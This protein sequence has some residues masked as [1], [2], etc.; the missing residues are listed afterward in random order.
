MLFIAYNAAMPTTAAMA[1]VANNTSGAIR[2]MLQIAPPSTRPMR[3]V[4]WGVT[5][6][7]AP[8]T[9]V[10]CELIDTNVAATVTAHVAAGVQPYDRTTGTPVSAMTLGTSATGYTATAEG[11]I[12]ATR[13]GDMK[14]IPIGASNLEYEWSLGREWEVAPSRFCRVRLTSASTVVSALV[15]ILWDE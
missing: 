15:W 9:R 13:I 11:T 3:P 12:T 4:R 2:T 5:L 6:P 10:D 14:Y 7:A 8:T 1:A